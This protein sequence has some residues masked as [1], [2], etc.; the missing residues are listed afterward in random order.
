MRDLVAIS[1]RIGAA[2]KARRQTVAVG[3]S[4]A[5]GLITAALLAVPGASAWCLGGIVIYTR[6]G[7]EALRDFDEQLLEGYRSST[8]GNARVRAKVARDRFGATWGLGETGAAGPT[9]NRYGDP[10]GHAC[11]AVSGSK[12]VSI[13]LKTGSADRLANMH[14][15]SAAAL[16]LLEE[17]L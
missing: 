2:L 4:S 6:Q 9:G 17:N 11:L 10:A 12:E 3:E 15:F 7:W 5:G 8:E 13:T 1:E 14:A 16:R